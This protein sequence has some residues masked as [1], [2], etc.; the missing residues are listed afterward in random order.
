M[1]DPNDNDTTKDRSV[2]ED[3]LK[4]DTDST[5]KGAPDPQPPVVPDGED[6][7]EFLTD[8]AIAEEILAH[9]KAHGYSDTRPYSEYRAERLASDA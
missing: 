3:A 8:L 9:R 5:P 2:P 7:E 1:A 4:A 6:P